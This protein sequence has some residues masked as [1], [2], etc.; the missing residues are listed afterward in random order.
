MKKVLLIAS[1]GFVE[2]NS[3]DKYKTKYNIKIFSFFYDNINILN[4]II[5]KE[6]VK[7][8]NYYNIQEGLN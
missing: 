3:I 6:K 7:L 5:K 8:F 1:N 4:Y 2:N